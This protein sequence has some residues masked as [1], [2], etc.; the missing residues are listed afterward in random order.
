MTTTTDIKAMFEAE[1][2]RLSDGYK[3]GHF[4]SVY[5]DRLYEMAEKHDCLCLGSGNISINWYVTR[6]AERKPVIRIEYMETT[7]ASRKQYRNGYT[8][9]KK[10]WGNARREAKFPFTAEGLEAALSF[11]NSL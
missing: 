10:V 11:A 4:I 2:K 6:S 1:A 7:F 9:N 8:F 3:T 5:S